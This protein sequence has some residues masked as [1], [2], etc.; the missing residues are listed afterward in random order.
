[1]SRCANLRIHSMA[2]LFLSIYESQYFENCSKSICEFV[3]TDSDTNIW[4]LF[5]AILF[6]LKSLYQSSVFTLNPNDSKIFTYRKIRKINRKFRDYQFPFEQIFGFEE[7]LVTSFRNVVILWYKHVS[8]FL[9]QLDYPQLLKFRIVS[10]QSRNC[11]LTMT[12]IVSF[13]VLI[14]AGLTYYTST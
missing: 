4:T 12:Y 5:V 14:S 6:I 7:L 1:M 11:P 13:C 3:P 2:K 9:F 10:W 8:C